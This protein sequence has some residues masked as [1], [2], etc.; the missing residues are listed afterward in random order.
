MRRAGREGALR[1]HLLGGSD[2]RIGA[3]VHAAARH[4]GVAQESGVGVSSRRAWSVTRAASQPLSLSQT[5]THVFMCCIAHSFFPHLFGKKMEN[6]LSLAWT[7]KSQVQVL[8]CKVCYLA[9]RFL[10]L[11]F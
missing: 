9:Q 4:R 1:R 7:A 8:D 5:E 11:F 2:R 3:L 6:Q 10:P